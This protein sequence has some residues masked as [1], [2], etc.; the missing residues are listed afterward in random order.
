M[1]IYLKIIRQRG[2]HSPPFFPRG[3]REKAPLKTSAKSKTPPWTLWSCF[4]APAKGP[5]SVSGQPIHGG[6]L[7]GRPPFLA[8]AAKQFQGVFSLPFFAKAAFAAPMSCAGEA[9]LRPWG[10]E[11]S[12]AAARGAFGARGFSRLSSARL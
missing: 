9:S 11:I 4:G 6:M 8:I 1:C 7:F 3:Q 5:S 2:P 10:P 12:S